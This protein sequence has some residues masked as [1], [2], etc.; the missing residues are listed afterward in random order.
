MKLRENANKSQSK[1]EKNANKS[2]STQF[3]NKD[4]SKFRLNRKFNKFK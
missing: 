2:K 4:K 1:I 3:E